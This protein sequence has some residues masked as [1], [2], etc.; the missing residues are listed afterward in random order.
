V[1]QSSTEF[2]DVFS[3]FVGGAEAIESERD[4]F[5]RHWVN[6]QSHCRQLLSN[7]VPVRERQASRKFSW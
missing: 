7:L 3:V 6:L 1:Y 5:S 4:V 2:E